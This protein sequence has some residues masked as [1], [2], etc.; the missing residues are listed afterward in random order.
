[1]CGC[2]GNSSI[3]FSTTCGK[4]VDRLV[5]SRN[6]L[7]ILYNKISDPL[8]KNKYKEDRIDI[9]EIIKETHQTG[10]CPD[11]SVIILI[12]QEVNNEYSKYN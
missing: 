8:L 11:L 9:D 4:K 5:T 2:G 12:E 1:M 7:A 6:K 3:G 10:T